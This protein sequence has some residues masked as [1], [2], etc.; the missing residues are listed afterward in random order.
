LLRKVRESNGI[1]LEEISGSTKITVAHLSAVE[2]G[3]YDEL[4]AE[5]DVRG[6]VQQLARQLKLDPAQVV[7][8]YMRRMREALAA[9][10]QA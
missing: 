7:K 9:R 8:T 2:D 1:D 5:V 3:R 4:P 10:R 6:F